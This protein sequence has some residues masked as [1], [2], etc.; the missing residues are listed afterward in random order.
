MKWVWSLLVVLV[1][2]LSGGAAHAAG[3]ADASPRAVSHSGYIRGNA[4]TWTSTYRAVASRDSTATSQAIS[5]ADPLAATLDVERSPGVAAVLDASERITTFVIDTERLPT[6]SYEIVVT[7]RA[8]RRSDGGEEVLTP[9]LVKMDGAQ[10]I[11]VAGEGEIRFE[12][13]ASMGLVHHVGAWSAPS[14]TEGARHEL[15]VFLGRNDVPVDGLPL[16]VDAASP[17]SSTLRGH[18]LTSDERMRPGLYAA[19]AA[20]VLLVGA[21]AVAYQ[22]LASNARIEEAEAALRSEFDSMR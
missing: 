18:A 13:S 3:I 1:A 4:I 2:L 20:F 8:P 9:P 17:A 11:D 15:D 5:L 16:F 21:I 10:R 7:L 19:I 22:W 12:P 14:I 6:W